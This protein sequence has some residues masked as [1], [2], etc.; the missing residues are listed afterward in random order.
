MSERLMIFVDGSN[1][2]YS[3]ERYRKGYRI[4]LLKFIEYLSKDRDKIRTYYFAS[5]KVP[6]VKQQTAF[7]DKLQYEGIQI[8]TKPLRNNKEKGIDVALVTRFLSL[9]FKNAYDTAI[10]VS[11]DK[12]YVS[13][14][15]EMKSVGKKVEVACF[16]N[17]LGDELHKHCDRL[18]K[19]DDFAH[20]VERI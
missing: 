9:G 7:F 15:D 13:A 4:D 20:L 1:L 19:I 17:C 12:D 8:E 16:A 11:G 10:I 6:P 5:T 3:Q 14:V 2:F 18:I